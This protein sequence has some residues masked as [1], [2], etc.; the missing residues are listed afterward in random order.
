MSTAESLSGQSTS[1]KAPAGARRGIDP[2]GPRFTASVTAV[3][4]LVVL[5]LGLAGAS[6]AATI[7]VAVVAAVFAW[8][9]AAGVQRHPVGA[10][11]RLLVRPRLAPPQELEDPAAPRFAQLVGLIVTGV[12]LI[13]GLVGVPYAVP[14]AAAMAFIAAFLNAVFGYC[15]GCQLYVLLLRAGVIKAGVPQ[16][17][18]AA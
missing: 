13:L 8:A 4:L 17:G 7:L 14:V 10:I 11:F 3:A 9:A 18:I 1:P 6:L 5:F 16:A 2:R 15:I 12:G